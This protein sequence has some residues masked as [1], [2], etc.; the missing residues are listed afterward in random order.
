MIDITNENVF[1]FYS[2]QEMGSGRLDNLTGSFRF[3]KNQ[4]EVKNPDMIADG[5][6][7]RVVFSLMSFINK[8]KY[9]FLNCLILKS[10]K[11][12]RGERPRCPI[13]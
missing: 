12:R 2:L 4:G 1:V 10:K 8:A 5:N 3:F 11:Q 9:A 6:A 7:F 13:K